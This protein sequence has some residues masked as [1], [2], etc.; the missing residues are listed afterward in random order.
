MGADAARHGVRG[1]PRGHLGVLVW[2]TY[3]GQ[4]VVGV[5]SAFAALA[6]AVTFAFVSGW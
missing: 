3:P 2:G 5:V 1:G 6:F 4:W